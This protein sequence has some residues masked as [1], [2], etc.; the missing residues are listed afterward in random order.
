PETASVR[1]GSGHLPAG[2]AGDARRARAEKGH[3]L[4]EKHSRFLPRRSRGNVYA[5][6]LSVHC[7]TA[8]YHQLRPAEFSRVARRRGA[9]HGADRRHA[10]AAGILQSR[11]LTFQSDA[12]AVS[13]SSL[14]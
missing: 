4:R 5:I 8:A 1:A 14:I 7:L 9:P 3:G 13:A 10:R 6:L 12:L 11:R 2:G